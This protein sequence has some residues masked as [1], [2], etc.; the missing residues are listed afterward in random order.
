MH[1][2]SSVMDALKHLLPILGSTGIDVTVK[3]TLQDRNIVVTMTGSLDDMIKHVWRKIHGELKAHPEVGQET[4]FQYLL[5]FR[6]KSWVDVRA[7]GQ[8]ERLTLQ[9]TGA[10]EEIW[11]GIAVPILGDLPLQAKADRAK[12]QP[13]AETITFDT[14]RLRKA[15]EV[16]RQVGQQLSGLRLGIPD[17]VQPRT[18]TINEESTDT[19]ATSEPQENWTAA[20]AQ[21]V[22]D[23]LQMA[24]VGLREAL[25]LPGPIPDD[26]AYSL[27][28]AF[29]L[30]CTVLRSCNAKVREN[31]P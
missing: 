26:I 24:T 15:T 5:E 11:Y 13:S 17:P 18:E 4:L 8:T 12:A 27:H 14:E 10:P 22:S 30:V 23:H 20:D 19:P 6:R 3:T 31:T 16:L 2:Q 7:T 1:T 25:T 29:E 28:G 9:F 21:R